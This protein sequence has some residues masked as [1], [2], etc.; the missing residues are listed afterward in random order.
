MNL[1]TLNADENE[2][3]VVLHEKKREFSIF[4]VKVFPKLIAEP[5]CNL[6]LKA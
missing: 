5:P 3:I 6:N 4:A 1:Y 2:V